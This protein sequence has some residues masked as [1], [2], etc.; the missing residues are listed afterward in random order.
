MAS[1]NKATFNIGW[2]NNNWTLNIFVQQT[3]TNILNL[4]LDSSNKFTC[5]YEQLQLM[6]ID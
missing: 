1:T 4:S 6:V 3:L 2:S 5:Q